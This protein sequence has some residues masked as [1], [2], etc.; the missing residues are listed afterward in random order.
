MRNPTTLLALLALAAPGRAQ[1]AAPP[2]R[3][4]SLQWG[5]GTLAGGTPALFQEDLASL[6]PRSILLQQDLSDHTFHADHY[7]YADGLFEMSLGLRV[8]PGIGARAPELRVGVLYSRTGLEAAFARHTAVPYDTLTSAQTGQQFIVD[9]V[10]TST[11]DIRYSAERF[12]V[13][14]ALVWSRPARWSLYAGIGVMG[15]A[16]LNARTEVRHEVV[17]EV[18]HLGHDDPYPTRDRYVEPQRELH[19]N[20]SGWWTGGYVPLGVDFRLGRSHVF[21][22]RIHLCYEVRPM[23]MVQGIPEIGS[24]TTFH[25]APILLLRTTF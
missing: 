17:N 11:Y 5:L 2:S 4:S 8:F 13:H 16:T 14:A 1:E 24:V 21:W 19:R 7:G 6:A 3:V 10:S 18:E 12:G 15:G 25:V 9:S 20:R 22:S 23:L